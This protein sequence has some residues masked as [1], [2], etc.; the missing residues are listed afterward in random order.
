MDL[1]SLSVSCDIH[2]LPSDIRAPGSWAFRLLG[3]EVIASVPLSQAFGLELNFLALQLAD[4]R[5]WDAL[6]SIIT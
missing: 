2:L 4:G 6:A 3:M 5:L 1:F